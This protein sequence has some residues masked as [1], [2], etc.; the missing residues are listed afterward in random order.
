VARQRNRPGDAEQDPPFEGPGLATAAD[1]ADDAQE[2]GLYDELG[3]DEDSDERDPSVGDDGGGGRSRRR[4]REG[5]GGEGSGGEVASRPST[6]V[7]LVR[8]LQGSWRE[9]HR[10]QWPD[11]PQVVQATGVVIGFVIVAGA[12]LAGADWVSQHIINFILK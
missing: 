1:D 6:M 10:V 7:R 4:T 5:A 9:L 11:R 8:F 3:Y 2:D 12:F